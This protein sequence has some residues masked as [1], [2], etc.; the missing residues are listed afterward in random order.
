MLAL[1]GYLESREDDGRRATETAIDLHAAVARLHA[2]S[3]S[4]ATKLQMHPGIHG[5]LVLLIEGDIERGRS[6]VVG[7]VL[8][9]VARLCG[10]AGSGEILVSAE[11]LGRQAHFFR[12]VPLR[13]L[14]I[15]GRLNAL[16]VVRVEGRAPVERRIDAAARRGVVPFVGRAAALVELARSRRTGPPRRAA[17]GTGQRRARHRQDAADRR[18][19][20][21]AGPP[22][23]PH[24]SRL[25]RRLSGR[26]TAAAVHAVDTWRTRPGHSGW[27]DTLEADEVALVSALNSIGGDLA[28]ELTPIVRAL[29]GRRDGSPAAPQA[30]VRTSSIVRSV[31]ALAL[32]SKVTA[33]STLSSGSSKARRTE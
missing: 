19:P 22:I 26:R 2:R 20:E 17:I 28:A 6:D 30:T 15:R 32:P 33:S 7:E 3:G 23:P 31:P 14:P 12:V 16:V 21:A 8:N 1:F 27:G 9:T 5:G 18:V 29:S 11:T 24:S 13:Q 25:L 10:L 4:G